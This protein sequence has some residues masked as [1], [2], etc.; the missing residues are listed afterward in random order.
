MVDSDSN[1]IY[2]LGLSE[3]MEIIDR[4]RGNEEALYERQ[5]FVSEKISEATKY[6][7]KLKKEFGS[8]VNIPNKLRTEHAKKMRSAGCLYDPKV[9]WIE[10]NSHELSSF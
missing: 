7:E 3:C 10:P 5:S 8:W 4:Y 6:I 9:G 1:L 2:D